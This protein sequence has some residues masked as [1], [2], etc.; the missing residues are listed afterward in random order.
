MQEARTLLDELKRIQ[1]MTTKDM[2]LE[3]LNH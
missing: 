2:W 1:G 3:D